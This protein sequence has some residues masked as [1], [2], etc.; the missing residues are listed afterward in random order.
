M[1]RTAVAGF[2]LLEVLVAV[3]IFALV[4]IASHRLLLSA[5][6]VDAQTRQ[7]EQ[8]LRQLVRA[9]SSLERDVEQALERPVLDADGSE[10]PAF[11]SDPDGQGLQWTRAGWG[12]PLAAPR[13]QLQR[14]RWRQD[15]TV[16]AREYWPVL[17][18]ADGATAQRQVVLPDVS[19]VQ[20]RYL[21]RQGVWRTQWHGNDA[22]PLPRALELRLQHPRFGALRR[23]LVLPDGATS[24]RPS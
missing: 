3:A 10:E 7:Q 8:Q 14:V 1:K 9:M 19:G 11:W 18:R 22:Q 20:W 15:G 2:T 17:D 13:A 23:V 5:V 12:N 4:G 24:G 16:L 6:R 21:D